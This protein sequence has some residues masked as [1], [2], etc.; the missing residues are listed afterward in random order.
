MTDATSTHNRPVDARSAPGRQPEPIVET[1]ALQTLS[2]GVSE[3]TRTPDR[4]DHNQELY[5]L[6]YAHHAMRPKS[7]D[8]S[9]LGPRL[10]LQLAFGKREALAR[11]QAG[12]AC[13]HSPP[14]RE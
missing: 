8:G 3:G 14:Y 7:S 12:R 2:R 13:R 11:R 5:Q 6:S 9:M 10:A 4:L 1:A